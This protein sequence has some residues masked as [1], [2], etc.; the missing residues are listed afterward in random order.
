[1]AERIP[2]VLINGQAKRLP[3]GDVI[4][5]GAFAAVT[6][7]TLTSPSAGATGVGETPELTSSAFAYTSAL[8]VTQSAAQWRIWSSDGSTL[9]YDSG[10]V[11][12]DLTAHT[13][14]AGN[15]SAST[16]YLAEVRHEGSIGGWSEYSARVSFTTVTSFASVIGLV[17][18]A[19]GGGAGTWQRVDENFDAKTTDASFFNNHQTYAGIVDE[20]IDSQSMVKIPKFWFR[21]GTV[22]SGTYAGKTYW[23]IADAA[24]SGFAVHP[25]FADG[26]GGWRDH[27]WVGKYQGTDDSGTQLGSA[28]GTTPLVNLDFPTMQSRAAARN[29]G[30]VTGF[31]LWDYHMLGGMQMLASIEMGG[32]DSQ[33]LIG[34]GRVSAGSAANTDATDVAQATWRGFVGLWG[35]VWQ[36]V[37]GLKRNGGKWWLWNP[38]TQTYVDTGLSDLQ[39][40]GYPVTFNTSLLSSDGVILPA[41]ADGTAGNGSTGDYC[42]SSTSTDDRIAYHGGG[43]PTGADAGLFCLGVSGTPSAGS[44]ISGA[45]LA[46]V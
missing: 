31:R 30:G 18:V 7:P 39:T 29:T 37:D 17:M 14:P 43:W 13:V 11:T 28:S 25:M 33:S 41:T 27:V 1:M 46:K 9:I 16:S 24:V 6:T 3:A 44:T 15:L 19:S 5:S 40:S 35:N 23:Q 45:R 36:M 12:G 22:P 2:L 4:P 32:L 42:W 34:Q 26:A 21:A 38:G 20:T 8:T 10:R